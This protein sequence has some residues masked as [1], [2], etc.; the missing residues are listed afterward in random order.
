MQENV[1]VDFEVEIDG[2]KLTVKIEKIDDKNA[3]DIIF[4]EEKL[5]TGTFKLENL[6]KNRRIL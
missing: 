6:E 5:C 1:R 3:F 4:K 2:E